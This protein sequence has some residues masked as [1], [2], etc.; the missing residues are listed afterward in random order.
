MAGAAACVW[1]W[2][3]SFLQSGQWVRW[4]AAN[5]QTQW[6]VLQG[7]VVCGSGWRPKSGHA[8]ARGSPYLWTDGGMGAQGLPVC[9]CWQACVW[10]LW[11]SCLLLWCCV[12]WMARGLG[13]GGP[14]PGVTSLGGALRLVEQEFQEVGMVCWG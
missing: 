5:R 8:V 10:C 14:A 1:C 2:G 4:C 6:F 3:L 12:R 9:A 13:G 7:R 11:C